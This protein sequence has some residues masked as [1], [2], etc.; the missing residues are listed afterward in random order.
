MKKIIL[1][2]SAL[3]GII[4]SIYFL[5]ISMNPF[6]VNVN[7]ERKVHNHSENQAVSEHQL[8]SQI[9]AKR[10]YS[11]NAFVQAN[12]IYNFTR[13]KIDFCGEEIPFEIQDV[14]ERFERDFLLNVNDR[15]Q[16]TMYLKR[17][18]RFFPY[19]EKKLKEAGLPDD[20]KYL[21]V[22]ESNL[23]DIPSPA[24]AAGMWH[25]MPGVAR[26]LGLIVNAEID[27]RYNL[28]KSTE[29]AFKYLKD[30]YSRFGSWS[31]AAASYNMGVYG[32]AD[33]LQFQ[34][35]KSYYELFLNRE[36]SRYVFR[37]AVIKEIMSNAELYGYRGI[38][39]YPEMKWREQTV[40]E[41]I[42][43]LAVWALENKLR[44]RDLK[45]YNPWIRSRSLP[46]P[47]K[48]SSWVLKL[49]L[50]E[51]STTNDQY[52]YTSDLENQNNAKKGFHVVREGETLES[53]SNLCGLSADELR[54]L[55]KLKPTDVIK[56]GQK[57]KIS[58]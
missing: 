6:S 16:I 38:I 54:R 29:A 25:I 5:L 11:D 46:S 7:D 39:I 37:I 27:E 8:S 35:Q 40:N 50:Q 45:I 48:G 55:N 43:N 47:A 14:F 1:S 20:L 32:V 56:T 17:S 34:S 13:K 42:P 9:E 18:G 2:A 23:L 31:L 24:G 28:D 10:Q 26:D 49:P 4:V 19:F 12:V 15:T 30:A 52:L 22:A 21:V 44:Y 57:L 58:P 51:T 36:T 33:E 41:A 3:L 53:I